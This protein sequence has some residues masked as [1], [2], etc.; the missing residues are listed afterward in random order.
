MELP[1]L[2]LAGKQVDSYELADDLLNVEVDE[3]LLH[4]AV[5]RHLANRRQGTHKTKTRAEVRGTGRKPWRQKGT[6]RARVGSVRSPIWRGGG[7]THGTQPRDYSKK[8][9]AKM[10]RTALKHAWVSKIRDGEVL[11]LED[12]K[13]SEPKTKVMY[14]VLKALGVDGSRVLL[15]LP[16]KDEFV[17]RSARNLSNLA[18]LPVPQPS[19]YD[20]L[21]AQHVL[22]TVEGMKSIEGRL[23][24]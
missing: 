18:L 11:V 15:L 9:N 22:T 3:D 6:G 13:L 21:R 17:E 5:V 1:I 2:N 23:G 20:L 24:S 19:V 14:G 8:L 12:V 4:I 16:D 10:K 7:I